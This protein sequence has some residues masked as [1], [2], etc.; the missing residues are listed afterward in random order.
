MG[1]GAWKGSGFDLKTLGLLSNDRI[2]GTGQWE[3]KGFPS[4]EIVKFSNER[5][6]TMPLDAIDKFIPD[7]KRR[8]E[9]GLPEIS[10]T[11]PDAEAVAGLPEQNLG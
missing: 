4:E 3:S 2:L 10:A 1:L 11:Q 7:K 9:L 5:L 8:L 6:K